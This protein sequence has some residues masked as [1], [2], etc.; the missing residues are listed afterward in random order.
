MEPWLS[1]MSIDKLS[2]DT[3]SSIARLLE[4]RQVDLPDGTRQPMMILRAV[5]LAH[6]PQVKR[7]WIAP[8]I[9][10]MFYWVEVESGNERARDG[11]V[12]ALSDLDANQLNAIIRLRD[13]LDEAVGGGR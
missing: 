11:L 13:R 3:L 2:P 8:E 7:S 5:L 9:S 1:W 12:G 10:N 4:Q 6:P